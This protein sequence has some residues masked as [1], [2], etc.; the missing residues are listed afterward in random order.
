[1]YTFL[2]KNLTDP[3]LLNSIVFA[4]IRLLLRSALKTGILGNASS[5][6]HIHIF[7]IHTHHYRSNR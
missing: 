6:F 4:D 3:K 2:F 5:Q 7:H 1:M